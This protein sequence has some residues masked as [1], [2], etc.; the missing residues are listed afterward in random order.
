MQFIAQLKEGELNMNNEKSQDLK[1]KRISLALKLSL[2]LLLGGFIY[3]VNYEP[4]PHQPTMEEATAN[5]KEAIKLLR[6]THKGF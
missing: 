6:D 5:V 1:L 2:V 3:I 4:K